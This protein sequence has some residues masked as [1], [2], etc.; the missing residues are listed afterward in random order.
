MIGV[1]LKGLAARKV[2]ALLT[3]F[4]VVIGVSMVSGTYVLT[5]TMQRAFDGIYTA[6]YESSDAVVSGKE[7]VAGSSSGKASVPESLL[8]KV[9][10]VPG[11]EAAAGTIGG[12]ES[13]EAEI[14]GRDGKGLAR[15][16]A[17]AMAVGHDP[18][19][20]QFDPLDLKTGDWPS[21]ASQ[22]VID[23]STADR[24]GYGVGD[25]VKVSTFGQTRPYE[26]TGIATF[27]GVNSLGGATITA[28]ELS[29][30][31]RLLHKERVFDG[32]SIAAAKGT[33][34]AEVVRSVRP[35]LPDSLQVRD[36]AAE[37]KIQAEESNEGLAFIRY[38]L[39]GFGAIALF[40]GAFVIFNTFS[41]TVA[42]RTREFATLRTL[43]ASRR[44]VMR[45]VVVEGLFIG[46]IASVIG[47]VLG[48][49]VA[50]GINELFKALGT[51]LPEGGTVIA[52][53][54]IIVSLLIGTVI[55]L[56]ASVLPARRA[57]RVP[58]IAAVRDG[59]TLPPSRLAAHSLKASLVVIA[60]AL[61]A[62]SAGVFAGG[63]GA[64]AV[65]LLLGGGVLVLF[66]GIALAAPSMVEPM[67]RVVG[68]PARRAGGVAGDLAN[69][70]ASRNP[71]RTAST[72]AALMVGLTLVTVVAV[73]GAGLRGSVESA[74]TD[75]VRADYILAGKDGVAFAAA[76][77]DALARVGG[78]KAVSHVRDDD[79]IVRGAEQIVTG[80]DPT[81]IGRFYRFEWTDGSA[82]TLERLGADGALVTKA[83][84][85]KENLSVG[86]ALPMQSPSGERRTLV[87]RGVYD[88][89]QIDAM[90]GAI[91]ISQ[92]SFDDVFPRPTNQFT[93]LEAGPGQKTALAAAARGFNDAEF[94]TGEAF[95]RDRTKNFASFLMML[96]V[97][98]A[99]SVVVSLFGMVNTLVLSVFE[100]TRELGMLRTIGMTRRQARRMIRHES[101]ITALI[102]ATLGVGLGVFLAALV[103]R[104]LS[105]YDVPLV[106]P[107]P[108]LVA[109]TAVAVLAGVVAAIP[110][111]RR[112]SRLNVLQALQYE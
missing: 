87:V 101:I 77:G 27:G 9:R 83:Y 39:L 24:E 98:L 35:L 22:V 66:V 84:A 12:D 13:S 50:K 23:A 28:F 75:Q 68:W 74:V 42:Q 108:V 62:I 61:A 34:T 106:I 54:T 96:Y 90:L 41:I 95:A 26:V 103:T 11:V 43:G 37:A 80:V 16:G 104:A 105:D 1:A 29:T 107:V 93:F 112:A 14:I 88:P 79:A 30:A 47:L 18:A 52:S 111:A 20:P 71:G 110:P 85:D 6:S 89:P 21:G 33:P 100:R 32:I 109:F 3:A 102:G 25:T 99:F 31:Q 7:V 94:H 48:V 2:R 81:T 17:P 92:A 64:G 53:R 44:Q 19:N 38:F 91:T 69:A 59:A 49:G 78:V 97:L 63:L 51:D 10:A 36:S 86:D 70:N 73:L 58:P 76:E 5:D 72:A 55:T 45:S 4:A 56:L 8:A 67:A 40:V 46:V 82:A 57:T 65:A 60:L 15:G